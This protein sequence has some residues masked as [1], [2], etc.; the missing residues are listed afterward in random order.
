MARTGMLLINKP[1]IS[2]IPFISA[3]RPE[4]TAPNTTSFVLLYIDK[5]IAQA[6]CTKVFSVK[7]DLPQYSFI[8]RLIAIPGEKEISLDLYSFPFLIAFLGSEL[9]VLYPAR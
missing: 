5:R 9:M 8:D 7:P 2:S 6:P 1:I 3:G 4:T